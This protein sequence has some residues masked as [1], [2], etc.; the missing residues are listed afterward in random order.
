MHH[1]HVSQI[2]ITPDAEITEVLMSEVIFTNADYHYE[3]LKPKLFGMI[4]VIGGHLI[5]K[6]SRVLIKP[7]LLLPAKPEKAILTHPLVVKAVAEYVLWKGGRPHIA[8]SPA[9]GTFIKI[10]RDGGYENAFKGFDVEFKTFTGSVK[11]DVGKPFGQIDIAKEVFEADVVINLAKLKTHAQMLLTL[12]VKNMFGCVIGFKKP[13]WHLRCGIDRNM[14]ARL[15]V[16]I[17]HVINPAITIVDGILALQGNGPGKS[18]TP[19]HLGILVGG[20]DATAVDMAICGLLGLDPDKLPTISAAKKL[21]MVNATVSYSG[22][23]QRVENF[24]FPTTGSLVFGPRRFHRFMRKHMI[25]RPVADNRRCRLC[26]E[27]WQFCPAKAIDRDDTR[28]YFDYN[29]CIRCYCC[30]EICPYGALH[31][32]KTMPGRL[33]HKAEKTWERF[34]S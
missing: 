10:L 34:R 26:G 3:T 18:G 8:D 14:F 6:E 17:Y 9:L 15:L 5:K 13:E 27:C 29:R 11:V 2:G 20:R 33:L 25:Q 32:A 21:G 30:I 1:P 19:R 16:Q 22:D 7:N 31:A 24:I 12:G 23:F 4:D 28:I